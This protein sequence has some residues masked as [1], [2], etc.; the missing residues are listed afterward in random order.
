MPSILDL[1]RTA[2]ALLSVI[3]STALIAAT[4]VISASYTAQLRSAAALSLRGAG[5]VVSSGGGINAPGHRPFDDALRDQ[6]AQIDGVAR[7]RGER[8]LEVLSLDVAAALQGATGTQV[9]LADSPELSAY[10]RLTS[11]RLPTEAGETAI[12][13]S[14]AEQNGLAVGDTLKLAAF[15]SDPGTKAS[16]RVVGVLEVGPDATSETGLHTAFVAPQQFD[17]L[18]IATEYKH[19]Y[20]TLAPG[21]DADAVMRS[22]EAEARAYQDSA[23]VRSAEKTITDR[24]AARGQGSNLALKTLTI[25]SPLCALV[26]GIVIMTVF[27]TLV[28]RQTRY[29]GLLRAVGAGRRQ[30]MIAV[31]RTGSAIGLAGALI[32]CAVG[33]GAAAGLIASGALG[34]I[35]PDNLAIPPVSLTLATALGVGVTLVAL[36]RPARRAARVSPLVA[37][38]GAP[39]SQERATRARRAVAALGIVVLALGAGATALGVASGN[40]YTTAAGGALMLLGVLAGL[41]LLL[42]A[43]GAVLTKLIPVDRLPLMRLAAQGIRAEPQRA[44]ASATALLVSVLAGAVLLT[45]L[46]SSRST[47]DRINAEQSPTDIEVYGVTP[48]TDTAA[49]TRAVDSTDGIE[50]SVLVPVLTLGAT[51]EGGTDDDRDTLTVEVIDTAAIAPVARSIHGL[52]DLDDQTLIIG[53]IYEIPDGSRV[54]LTGSA[55]SVTLTARVR[56]GW[57]AVISPGAASE[58]IGDAPRDSVLWAR[59]HGDGSDTAP[60]AALRAALRSGAYGELMV[61]DTALARSKTLE[62]VGDFTAVVGGVFLLSLVITLVGLASTTEVSVLERTRQIGVM[63][64]L[65]SPASQVRGLILAENLLLALVAGL[66]GAGLGTVLGGAATATVFKETEA[67]VTVSLLPMAGVLALAVAVGALA[68][69]RPASKACEVAPVAALAED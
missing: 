44:A 4:L 43:I 9:N 52:E 21:A 63:R 18:G 31:L 56:E 27:T 19:I 55:G 6:L 12:S 13:S 39:V 1:R 24:T 14:L 46:A 57:G 45:G 32:G 36:L 64:A 8:A 62:F 38:T 37:L 26:A 51:T 3:L 40:L 53:G 42:T 25:L 10:T 33:A 54:T 65:G 30:V 50:A 59:A 49:L 58:L 48:E 28:A 67:H 5:V 29:I 17:A 34:A 20:L 68:S 2:A 15:K 60:G 11:G 41:P 22:A 66:I 16:L 35:S 7:A 47:F 61:Q 23:I 69:M